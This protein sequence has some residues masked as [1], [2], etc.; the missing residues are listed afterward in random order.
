MVNSHFYLNPIFFSDLITNYELSKVLKEVYETINKFEY[1]IIYYNSSD[2]EFIDFSNSLWGSKDPLLKDI[3]NY[4][5]IQFR[6]LTKVQDQPLNNIEACLNQEDACLVSISKDPSWNV[7]FYS[8]NGLTTDNIYNCN[9]TIEQYDQV[10]FEKLLQDLLSSKII[11]DH[12]GLVNKL[13]PTVNE[14]KFHDNFYEEYKKA[15]KEI[16]AKWNCIFKQ[17]LLG[18]KRIEDYDYHSESETVRKNT[19]LL[20]QREVNFGG[21]PKK[22]ILKH[23]K[24]DQN[25]SSYIDI[26]NS[27]IY[28]GKLTAHL[29]TKKY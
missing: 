1:P 8:Q 22:V 24:L 13:Y 21:E 17:L 15:P 23:L 25:W 9:S 16:V 2:Q 29:T 10:N 26:T 27:C 18:S 5:R 7:R 3:R 12:K 11:R 4:I 14:I 6:K 19:K 20:E 28:F